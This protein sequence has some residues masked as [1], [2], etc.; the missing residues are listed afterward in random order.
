M[1]SFLGLS[2]VAKAATDVVGA[3]RDRGQGGDWR[4][5]RGADQEPIARN[6]ARGRD[7]E[8]VRPQVHP[9]GLAEESNV[10]VIV[11]DEKRAG[12]LAERPQAAS[13]REHVATREALVAE[14]ED[15]G[16]TP[17]GRGDQ[18]GE[19]VWLVIRRNHIEAGGNKTLE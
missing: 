17:Q 6:G 13:Q 9:V 7:A 1:T 16:A 19:T 15:L 12:G 10:E 5:G 11:H 14:L 18:V 2:G 4:R 3:G 8:V